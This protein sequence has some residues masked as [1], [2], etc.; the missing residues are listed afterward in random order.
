MNAGGISER[1]NNVRQVVDAESLARQGA[2]QV[3]RGVGVGLC[4]GT[5]GNQCSQTEGDAQA[6]AT[7]T[8]LEEDISGSPS[9]SGTRVPEASVIADAELKLDVGAG[10]G[11]SA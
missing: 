5:S 2:R 4:R 3:N 10:T 11:D 7:P 8:G 9:E 6:N 1:A